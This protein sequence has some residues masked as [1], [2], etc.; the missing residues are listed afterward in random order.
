MNCKRFEEIGIAIL[1]RCTFFNV[2]FDANPL[3]DVDGLVGADAEMG[4]SVKP[5]ECR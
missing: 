1:V 2:I 5:N 3:D 4:S